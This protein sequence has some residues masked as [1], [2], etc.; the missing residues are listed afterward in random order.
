MLD[1]DFFIFI[2]S[3][4]NSI[5]P[6]IIMSHAFSAGR[7][8]PDDRCLVIVENGHRTRREQIK[9]FQNIQEPLNTFHTIIGCFNFCLAWTPTGA[10]FFLTLHFQI[11]G[12]PERKTRCPEMDRVSLRDTWREVLDVGTDAS[13]GPQLESVN[14]VGF[15]M[16]GIES[17][18]GKVRKLSRE[19]F[20]L[21]LKE[22]P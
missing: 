21:E 7:I 14:A 16:L 15:R 11:R 18:S 6:N 22:M 3:L 12:P 8:G 20:A 1:G 2:D 17:S 5:L 10:F 13:W 9:I 4:M 19:S